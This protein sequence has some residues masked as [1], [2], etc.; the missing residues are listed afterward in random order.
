MLMLTI[1]V[2]SV[3]T[4]CL[5]S[6]V[7]KDPWSLLFIYDLVV[8]A[9]DWIGSMYE[10]KFLTK[11]NWG[12]VFTFILGFIRLFI[13]IGCLLAG[14]DLLEA[15]AGFVQSVHEMLK[16]LLIPKHPTTNLIV[17][18]GDAIN[19]AVQI[20]AAVKS[21]NGEDNGAPRLEMA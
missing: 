7:E 19:T 12:D 17:V 5:L 11:T 4:D 13:Y 8:L 9:V 16:L 21:I 2:F 20:V 1:D 18:A 3:V 6:V 14:M 10:G 15:V